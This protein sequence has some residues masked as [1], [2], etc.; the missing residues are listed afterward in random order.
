MTRRKTTLAALIIGALVLPAAS[1]ATLTLTATAAY[2]KGPNGQGSGNG[3]ANKPERAR[4]AAATKPR[5]PSVHSEL[6]GA[7]AYHASPT[8]LEHAN[9]DSRVGK[10]AA[11]LAAAQTTISA[12]SAATAAQDTLDA[13][14]E[15]DPGYTAA[16]IQAQIDALDPESETYDE[17]QAELLSLL[18]IATTYEAGLAPLQDE[19][20]RLAAEAAAAAAAEGDTLLVLTDGRTLSDDALAVLRGGLGL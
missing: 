6:K 17:D 1:T 4:P 15:N 9:E 3:H 19:A 20:E 2:A 12:G 14:M 16:E 7:N 11:Y 8:A 5:G 10:V 18:D 13:Y